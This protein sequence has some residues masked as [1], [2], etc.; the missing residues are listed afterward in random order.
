MLLSGGN[1]LCLLFMTKMKHTIFDGKCMKKLLL[2]VICLL[3]SY[4]YAMQEVK[5]PRGETIIPI[6]TYYYQQGQQNTYGAQRAQ[7]AEAL[8]NDHLRARERGAIA[9]NR[10]CECLSNPS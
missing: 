9:I 7:V 3:G 5:S 6:Q 2:S 10:L 1:K 8:Y 4:S